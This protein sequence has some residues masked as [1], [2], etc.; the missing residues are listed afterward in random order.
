[1]LHEFAIFDGATLPT[2]SYNWTMS[3]SID[4]RE[5][6]VVTDDPGLVGEFERL[7][8]DRGNGPADRL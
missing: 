7:W 3:A 8:R 5:N 4:N 2:G 1:M 6:F